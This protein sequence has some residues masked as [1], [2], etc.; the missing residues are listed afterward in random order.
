MAGLG[1]GASLASEISK[2]GAGSAAP[3]HSNLFVGNIAEGVTEDDLK[4][5]FAPFGT[6][7]SVLLSSKAGRPSGFVKMADVDSATRAAAGLNGNQGWEVKFANYDVGKAPKFNRKGFGG[8]GWFP[9]GGWGKGGWDGG[10]GKSYAS[11]PQVLSNDNLYIQGLPGGADETSIQ[12]LLGQYGTIT[13]VKVLPTAG[14]PDTVAM[15]RMGNPTEAKWLVENLDGN[16]PQ[17]A[18][19]IIQIKFAN[20]KGS[21]KGGYGAA[22]GAD[23]GKGYSPYGKGAGPPQNV[24]PP[25]KDTLSISGLP[26]DC[27]GETISALIGQYGNVA[28][29]NMTGSGT[30]QVKMAD[31]ETAQWLV[32]NLDGNIPQGLEA[33][34]SIKSP[35]AAGAA[36]PLQ[37]GFVSGTV[38][39][40]VDERGMGFISPSDGS[41]ERFAT[42]AERGGERETNVR[43]GSRRRRRRRQRLVRVVRVIGVAF[44]VAVARDFF[45]YHHLGIRIL[46]QT[47][48]LQERVRLQHFHRSRE[49][50]KCISEPH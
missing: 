32:E 39:H 47:L 31:V 25:S 12:T 37:D 11:G 26:A 15:V 14:R 22:K 29:A 3:A 48:L 50:E 35:A 6:I 19:G 17:G 40:W 1:K 43:A 21:D 9:K 10:K 16:I 42:Q 33:P 7:E 27:T 8:Y 24:P 38:K 34:I 49:D 23:K 45:V 18:E 28:S 5:A 4:A 2:D 30:A 20:Q 13:S 46:L 44:L 36:M 41:P